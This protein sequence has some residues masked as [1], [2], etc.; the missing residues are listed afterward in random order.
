M[1]QVHPNIPKRFTSDRAPASQP[2]RFTG[3]LYQLCHA[4]ALQQGTYVV[5]DG[6]HDT[7]GVVLSARPVPEATQTPS[8]VHVVR[9]IPRKPGHTPA[10]RW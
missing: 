3:Q 10:V 7:F 5:I 2:D 6:P 1:Q 8:Y 9:G 4:R